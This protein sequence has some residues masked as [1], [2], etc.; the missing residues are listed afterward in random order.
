MAKALWL[1]P[2]SKAVREA[3]RLKARA[4]LVVAPAR[5]GMPAK[6]RLAVTKV[7]LARGRWRAAMDLR[8]LVS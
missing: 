7:R 3:Q 4:S 5:P 6:D 2:L 8:Y 1:L